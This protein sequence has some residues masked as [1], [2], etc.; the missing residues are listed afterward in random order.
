MFIRFRDWR[1]ISD[2]EQTKVIELGFRRYFFWKR[3]EGVCDVRNKKDSETIL[4]MTDFELAYDRYN[5]HW[6]EAGNQMDMNGHSESV[7]PLEQTS[8]VAVSTPA[9]VEKLVVEKPKMTVAE[10][11]AKAR[12]VRMANI[13]ARK[14]GS[15]A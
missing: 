7:G 12:A 6:D 11:L 8:T 15:N 13:A 4:K 5:I 10:R 9:E 2:Q 3:D 14:N 1:I